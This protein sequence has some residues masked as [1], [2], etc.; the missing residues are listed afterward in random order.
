MKNKSNS[1]NNKQNFFN[2]IKPNSICESCIIGL[3]FPLTCLNDI[4]KRFTNVQLN[5]I[6]Y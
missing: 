4:N 6:H 2:T 5:S 3:L 1:N